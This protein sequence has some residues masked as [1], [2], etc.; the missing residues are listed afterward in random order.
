MAY[1]IEH[2]VIRSDD[3]LPCGPRWFCDNRVA[4]QADDDG[5]AD[6]HYFSPQ[7]AGH[8]MVFH[9]AFWG[10]IR[11]Y[12]CDETHNYQLRPQG[13]DILPFGYTATV[14]RTWDAVFGCE[15][16]LFTAGDSVYIQL[17][18]DDALPEGLRLKL[19]FY[20]EYQFE[21]NLLCYS[22]LIICIQI[23]IMLA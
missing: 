13:C 9:R 6:I 4:F 1:T 14:R 2:G 15:L 3:G 8:T 21:K 22:S 5:I 17:R 12:L 11:L 18:T 16:S 10:G 23:L 19:E 20:K 7:G